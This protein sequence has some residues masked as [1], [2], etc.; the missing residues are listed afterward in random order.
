MSN[1][2]KNFA[3]QQQKKPLIMRILVLAL[4][5]LMIVGVVA[6][7]IAGVAV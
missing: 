3:P 7:A 5:A 2:K 6:S 1:S 4:C